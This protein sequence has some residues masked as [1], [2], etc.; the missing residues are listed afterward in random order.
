[1]ITNKHF[2]YNPSNSILFDVDAFDIS[3]LSD[4][5]LKEI[6]KYRGHYTYK[7][8]P[9]E[10]KKILHENDFYYCDTL[11][12]PYCSK[13]RFICFEDKLAT[14]G[15]FGKLEDLLHICKDAFIHGRFQRDFKLN[16]MMADQRYCNWL[17]HLYDEKSTYT[18]YYDNNLAGFVA[19]TNNKL[20]LHALDSKYRG[21]GLGKYFW[22][23]V[24]NDLFS[25]G[26]YEITSSVSATNLAVINLYSSLGF[27]FRNAL[28]V[29]HRVVK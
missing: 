28:D 23:R 18:L 8:N 15:D 25:K 10:C 27:K 22:S 6:V 3:V 2:N 1:M 4:L 9:L 7:I 24:C 29:Y 19:Y 14:I 20:V 5:T 13:N 17:T 16:K 26:H 12:E 11:L 21:K